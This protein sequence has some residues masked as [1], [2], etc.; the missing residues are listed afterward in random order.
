MRAHRC[1]VVL[2]MPNKKRRQNEGLTMPLDKSGSKASV[3]KNIKR[4]LAEGKKKSQAVAI[5]LD[6]ARRA[7]AKIPAK[8]GK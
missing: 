1:A 4:E 3:G 8:K 6:V 7:G 5:A 2:K